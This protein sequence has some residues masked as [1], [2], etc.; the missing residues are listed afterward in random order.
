VTLT[1]AGASDH[2]EHAPDQSQR[3]S[4]PATTARSAASK[5]AAL[6]ERPSVA[7][8]QGL[9]ALHGQ[10]RTTAAA[11]RGAASL[12]LCTASSRAPRLRR[13]TRDADS[14][15]SLGTSSPTAKA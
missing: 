13:G 9:T 5:S 7:Q 2:D 4:Q 15:V 6:P 8:R 11:R 3:P 10:V 1:R 12:R 14:V